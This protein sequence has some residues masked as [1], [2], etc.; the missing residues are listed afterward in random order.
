MLVAERVASQTRESAWKRPRPP[1][2]WCSWLTPLGNL[3]DLSRRALELFRDAD[4]I[5]CA[6]HASLTG[7]L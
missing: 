2:S 4:V 3:G 7:A 1:A 5:Y 6:A